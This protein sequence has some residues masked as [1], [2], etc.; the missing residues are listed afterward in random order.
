MQIGFSLQPHYDIPMEQMIGLLADAGFSTVSPLWSAE[1]DLDNLA[2]WV[3]KNGM[4]FSFIHASHKGVPLIWE[5]EN[6]DSRPVVHGM[7]DAI[8]AC[9]RFGIP[10]LV[11]HC[12]QGL[13]YTFPTEPLDFRNVDAVV[14]RA[15]SKEI[16][17]AFENLEG[18]EYLAAVLERYEDLP[19]IGFCWD[20]GHDICHPH[21]ADYL[22]AYGD[23]LIMPHLNDNLGVRDPGGVYCKKDDLHLLPYDGIRD[24]DD[25]LARLARA[26]KQSL[27]NF[28]IKVR[29][30]D[31][32]M[33]P[34]E[35]LSAEEFVT[36]A[37]ERAQKIAKKYE[38]L[39]T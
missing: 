15:V 8:D 19:Q 34:Y 9:D 3:R 2:K 25:T 12:W 11:M 27:L 20:T 37:A 16:Y 5:P 21:K 33:V 6:A 29:S 35:K 26:K 24:W 30:K 39:T 32:E 23:R 4:D 10:M 31:P 36:L 22:A 1:L 14:E 13:A 38:A 18:E 7:L 28:E 17:I